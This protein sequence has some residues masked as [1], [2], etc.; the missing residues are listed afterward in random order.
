MAETDINQREFG[1]NRLKVKDMTK[2]NK[3]KREFGQNR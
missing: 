2:T 1:L 3:K